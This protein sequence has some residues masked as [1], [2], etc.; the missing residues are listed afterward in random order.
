[1][2]DKGYSTVPGA[3]ALD[4]T[5]VLAV[6]QAGNSRKVTTQAIA[7]LAPA[8]SLLR[9]IPFFF[10]TTP[11]SLEELAIYV[12]VD[13]FTI[14]ANMAGSQV[15]VGVNPSATFAIDVQKAPVATPTVFASI[16]TITIATSGAPSL[17]TAGG[18]AKPIV[19][20]EVIR[21]LGPSSV[22]STIANVAVNVKGTL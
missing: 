17:T 6:T 16:G 20:G 9:L 15:A 1:M 21:F 12:A 3:G 4:G 19:T 11:L 7:N 13:P 2:A 14:P 22:D 5:E 10:T 18:T 8:G